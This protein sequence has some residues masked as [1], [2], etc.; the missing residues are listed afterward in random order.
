MTK[1]SG[2][3]AYSFDKITVVSSAWLK[4]LSISAHAMYIFKYGAPP[5]FL[6]GLENPSAVNAIIAQNG[7]TYDE[8]FSKDPWAPNFN[9]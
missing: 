6:L 7:N 5:G 1:G 9:L 3:I 8:G 2:D 4:K